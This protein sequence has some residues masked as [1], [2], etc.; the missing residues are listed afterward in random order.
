MEIKRYV[1]HVQ[2]IEHNKVRWYNHVRR[3]NA[4]CKNPFY[5]GARKEEE[6]GV[7][8]RMTWSNT[9]EEGLNTEKKSVYY[10]KRCCDP[11]CQHSCC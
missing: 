9:S 4:V 5:T 3:M 6:G 7:R 10:N 2:T 11:D 8:R 1:V